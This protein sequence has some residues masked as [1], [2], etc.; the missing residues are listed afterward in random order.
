[1]GGGEERSE[2][3]GRKE[4]REERTK[5]RGLGSGAQL[6]SGLVVGF[7]EVCRE[8]VNLELIRP[9][10]PVL[11]EEKTNAEAQGSLK[12]M[13]IKK[14]IIKIIDFTDRDLLPPALTQLHRYR[15]I[16]PSLRHCLLRSHYSPVQCSS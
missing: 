15:S 10:T 16:S 12:E 6:P 1:M 3:E 2:S 13:I 8:L 5:Q 14:I 4:G 9:L 11:R 7:K